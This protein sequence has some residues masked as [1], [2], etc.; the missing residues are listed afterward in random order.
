MK[1]RPCLDADMWRQTASKLLADLTADSL[2]DDR[3]LRR[4]GY[5]SRLIPE[6]SPVESSMGEAEFEAAIE[7][8]SAEDAARL[9]VRAPMQISSSKPDG[10]YVVEVLCTEHGVEGHFASTGYAR[11]I[12]GAWLLC[13]NGCLDR[14][15]D[16][17]T[18]SSLPQP[19]CETPPSTSLH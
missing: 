3:L 11:A 12:I 6:V 9:V 5:L 16:R 19:R 1:M 18:K 7:D 10:S 13:V 8:L 2:S 14:Q 4:A 15:C 17:D